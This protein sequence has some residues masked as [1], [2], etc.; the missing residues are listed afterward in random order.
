MNRRNL[1]LAAAIFSILPISLLGVATAA[2]KT[3]PCA[4]CSVK[5]GAGPEPV[6]ATATHQGKTFYFCQD[7]CKQE[8]LKNPSAFLKSD[9]PR[10]APSFKLK[11]LNGNTVSL[12][13]YKGKVVLLDFWATFCGPCIK[14]MPKLQ[15]LQEKHAAKGLAVV[16]IATD[17]EGA[18]VVAPMV[19]KTKV[20]Y[21]IL[22]SNEA[23]WKNYEVT[24]LPAMF[25]IDRQGQIVKRF[26]GGTDHKTVEQEV[27]RLLGESSR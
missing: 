3:A 7:G 2:P 8:F 11:D 1:M 4:V 27:E 26:G 24:A 22:L 17:E 23:A 16:G 10:P 18:K 12:E 9:A 25:L 19:A 15:K 14:A 13:D 6:R 20:K 5:E 21:P